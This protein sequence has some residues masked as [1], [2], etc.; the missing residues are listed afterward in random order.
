MANLSKFNPPKK[1]FSTSATNDDIDADWDKLLSSIERKE[2][3]AYKLIWETVDNSKGTITTSSIRQG[4]GLD[5]KSFSPIQNAKWK[6]EQATLMALSQS[7]KFSDT[8]RNNLRLM[9]NKE[10]ICSLINS[11]KNKNIVVNDRTISERRDPRNSVVRNHGLIS[12]AE[13]TKIKRGSK[14]QFKTALKLCFGLHLS[15]PES[16]ALLMAY[17]YCWQDDETSAFLKDELANG[18]FNAADVLYDW[19]ILQKKATVTCPAHKLHTR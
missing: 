19:D 14:C 12:S 5:S 13:F 18:R 3:A 17:G 8:Q 11:F 10:H 9:C 4:T 2:T 6:P 15:I 1:S 16:E 7:N